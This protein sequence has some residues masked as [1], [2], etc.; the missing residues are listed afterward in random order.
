MRQFPEHAVHDRVQKG[1]IEF[2]IG[3]SSKKC[4]TK[5][6][7]SS[8]SGISMNVLL[9]VRKVI[10]YIGL[11]GVSR[12]IQKVENRRHSVANVGFEGHAWDN[13]SS[14]R[15]SSQMVGIIGCGS[16][17]YSTIAYYLRRENAHFLKGAMDLNPSK[18]RSLVKRFGGKYATT[19]PKVILDDPD[20]QLVYVA[21]NH[22]SHAEYAIEAIM[23]GKHV[24]IEKPHVVSRSQLAALSDAM[25]ARP[26]VMVFLGFNRP[27]SR[28]VHRLLDEM[29]REAG[30]SMINWF[31]A[32]HA[33]EDDHWYFDPSE[34]GRILGN[35]S[36]WTDLTLELIPKASRFP[37]TIVP[38]SDGRSRSD[39]VTSIIFP[40]GSLATI[41]FSA[42]GQTFEG[43]R[44]VL[45]I[46]KGDLLAEIRDF[47]TLTLTRGPSRRLINSRHR[48]HGHRANVVNS[49]LAVANGDRSRQADRLH[50]LDTAELFLAVRDAHSTGQQV[51]V[52]GT[53][54]ISE[55]I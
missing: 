22:A 9:N 51:V 4:A 41:T 8:L 43:V 16:F 7:G 35:L 48:D 49:Y 15:R 14:K 23:R 37:C 13:Q 10:R 25:R 2:S 1:D 33:I 45:Q 36:H 6:P 21:S 32:G 52:H 19:D 53:T 28:Q 40:D 18:A 39:F 29:Q 30:P 20:I 44:E 50:V 55:Q 46:H 5:S 38:T 12:T 31:V 54:L 34:G 47:K 24:H 42:K 27:K 11:Y 26:D 3:L 17:S